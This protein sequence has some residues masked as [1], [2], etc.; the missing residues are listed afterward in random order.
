MGEEIVCVR[1]A[2]RGPVFFKDATA[3]ELV[4]GIQALVYENAQNRETAEKLFDL[5]WAKR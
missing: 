4:A 5:L 2:T 3:D 1:T